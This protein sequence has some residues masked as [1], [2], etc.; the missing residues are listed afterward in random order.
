M[1]ASRSQPAGNGAGRGSQEGTTL[2]I[3]RQKQFLDFAENCRLDS[4]SRNLSVVLLTDIDLT[5]VDFA[6]IPIFCGNFDGNGHTV[7]GLSITQD[8]SNMGLF[9][10]VDASALIQNLTVS[11]EIIPDGSRSAVGGIAGHNAGKIQNCFFDG[12]VSGSDDVGGIAGITSREVTFTQCANTGHISNDTTAVLSSG[13]KPKGGTGGI[14]GVGKSGNVSISLCYN[15]GTVSG[16][17]IVGGILGGEAGDYGTSISNGNPSLT[18]ENCYNAGLLDVGSR[19]NRIGSLVGFPIAGQYRDGLYVLGS[20]S[21]QAKG[22]FSSQGECITVLDGKTYAVT[23][24]GERC[25]LKLRLYELEAMLPASFIRI[26]KSALANE[27]HLER[28]T[29]SFN[30]TVDAVF[31]SGYREYVSRRCFAEIKRR[32]DNL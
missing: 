28:F 14:L 2:R 5:G 15:T 16:T 12:T 11:G 4:Y 32:Y 10:Y 24:S 3:L 20:S 19:T 8:G 29:A 27:A 21:R 7:S 22:W 18:V 1:S 9:R 17:T 25:R 13:E 6:G 30:G 26:N 23:R 31:R